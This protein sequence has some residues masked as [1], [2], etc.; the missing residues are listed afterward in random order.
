MKKRITAALTAVMLVLSVSVPVLSVSA[1]DNKT[2]AV[3]T[4][5]LDNVVPSAYY[6]YATETVYSDGYYWYPNLDAYNQFNSGFPAVISRKPTTAYSADVYCYFDTTVGDYVEKSQQYRD[7]VYYIS[8]GF[9]DETGPKYTSYLAGDGFYYPTMQLAKDHTSAKKTIG[10]ITRYGEGTYYSIYSGSF[11]ETYAE[12]LSASAGNASYIMISIDD[13][14]YD[15]RYTPIYMNATTHKYYLTKE[16]AEAAYKGSRITSSGTPTQGYYFSQAT[17]RFYDTKEGAA[18]ATSAKDV[19]TA[20]SLAYS[21]GIFTYYTSQGTSV[22]YYYDGI[23]NPYYTGSGEEAS[24]Q[25]GD[26]YIAGN[27]T[28]AGWDAIARY[29]SNQQNDSTVNIDMNKQLTVPREFMSTIKGLRRTIVFMNDNGSRISVNGKDITKTKAIDLTVTYGTNNV[30]AAEIQKYGKGALS[31]SQFT[32]GDG[33]TLG[34]TGKLTIKFNTSRSGKTVKLYRYGGP[35][36][37][38]ESID[39]SVIAKDGSCS[40]DYIT[41]GGNYFAV[42]LNI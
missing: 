5:P 20:T 33:T 15:F 7:D 32:F 18:Q 29:I 23:Y 14:Y 17:G 26:A 9:L 8:R 25:N 28:Y 35:N 13:V 24:A 19:I 37:L 21:N 34:F 3:D 31:S 1:A 2:A 22:P 38:T 16:D 6:R 36:G 11:Y 41:A 4:N 40:F 30:T 27:V 39:S 42:I 12:A 10:T